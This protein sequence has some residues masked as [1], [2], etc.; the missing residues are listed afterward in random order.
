ML[1]ASERDPEQREAFR[2]RSGERRASDFVSVDAMGSN[3]NLPPR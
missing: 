1:A 3:L 2:A